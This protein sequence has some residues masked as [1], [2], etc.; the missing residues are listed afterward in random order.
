[1]SEDQ[2]Q[3]IDILPSKDERTWAMLCH[4]SAYAGCGLPIWAYPCASHYLA[5]QK[6]GLSLSSRPGKR[7]S[8]FSNQYDSLFYSFCSTCHCSHWYPHFNWISHF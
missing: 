2:T 4:F 8:K 5:K 1:M 3:P 7:N 6:G